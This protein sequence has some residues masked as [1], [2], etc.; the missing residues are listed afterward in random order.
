MQVNPDRSW[1]TRFLLP[2]I[3]SFFAGVAILFYKGPGW[4]FFRFYV[5]DVVAVAFLYF[6]LSLFWKAAAYWR[7][8]A[9][10]A[11]ATAIEL[12]Q[13]WELTP[14]NG[15][16]VSTI[17]FGSQFELWDFVAYGVGLAIA[18]AVDFALKRDR[19]GKTGD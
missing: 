4:Q 16:F 6:L 10:G 15:S 14:K 17:V 8:A 18:L 3:L 5:G 19:Q 11:I 2:S 13:L 9:I 7:A 12:A 1:Q